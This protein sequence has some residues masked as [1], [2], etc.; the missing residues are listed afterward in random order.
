[1]RCWGKVTANAHDTY[2]A[3]FSEVYLKDIQYCAMCPD[4][5]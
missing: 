5:S 4:V 2:K 1:M 3:L